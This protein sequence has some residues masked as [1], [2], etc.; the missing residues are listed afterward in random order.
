[1]CSTLN[2]T[3]SH[4]R[5][6]IRKYNHDRTRQLLFEVTDSNDLNTSP[7]HSKKSDVDDNVGY[8]FVIPHPENPNWSRAHYSADI[9]VFKWAPGFLAKLIRKKALND[10]V[11]GTNGG[12]R[13]FFCFRHIELI[14]LDSFYRTQLPWVKKH[15]EMA[16]PDCLSQFL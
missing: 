16:H 3:R 1:V 6:T 7:G 10:A 13:L 4:G 14:P 5:W 15:S 2:K 8:W 11:S 9:S 12:C